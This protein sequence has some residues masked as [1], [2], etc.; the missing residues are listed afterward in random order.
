MIEQDLDF[1]SHAETVRA[2]SGHQVSQ[3][4]QVNHNHFVRL[5]AD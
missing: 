2:Q 3:A 1:S 4:R 5:L